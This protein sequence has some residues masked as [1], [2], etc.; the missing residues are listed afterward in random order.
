MSMEE[1]VAVLKKETRHYAKRQLTW[2][3]RNSEINWINKDEFSDVR[4]MYSKAF[5][6]IKNFL[7][8]R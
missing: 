2:F 1:A 6:I 4:D 5:E 3:R 7:E 8:K